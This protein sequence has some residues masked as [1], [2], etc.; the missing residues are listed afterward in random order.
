MSGKLIASA[1]SATDNEM[2]YMLWGKIGTNERYVK[3]YLG[4]SL[5][6]VEN[7]KKRNEKY[8]RDMI[9]LP[10]ECGNKKYNP[11]YTEVN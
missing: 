1:A 11:N 3:L 2:R 4:K 10:W 7:W 6:E 5:K 9:I 8:Y